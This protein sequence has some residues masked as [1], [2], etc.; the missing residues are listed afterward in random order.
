MQWDILAEMENGK[1][2]FLVQISEEALHVS[3][4]NF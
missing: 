2:L 1:E 4:D 3:L